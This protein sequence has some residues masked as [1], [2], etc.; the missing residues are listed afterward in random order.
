MESSD[1]LKVKRAFTISVY[2]A[3]ECTVAVLLSDVMS[4]MFPY[5]V[6][7]SSA[8]NVILLWLQKYLALCFKMQW[9]SKNFE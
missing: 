5:Y 3:N 6:I 1:V 2:F 4:V 9:H 8:A 7:I